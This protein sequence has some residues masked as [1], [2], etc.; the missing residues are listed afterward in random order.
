MWEVEEEL[1]LFLVLKIPRFVGCVDT[2]RQCELLVFYDASVKAHATAIYN[3][4]CIKQQKN[5]M[6]FCFQ[7]H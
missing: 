2:T 5:L 3:Y 1:K 6:S 4:L 7:W